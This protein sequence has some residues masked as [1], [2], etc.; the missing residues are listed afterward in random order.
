[1]KKNGK[2]PIISIGEL[3]K[4]LFTRYPEVKNALDIFGISNEKYQLYLAAQRNPVFF[5]SNTTIEGRTI[6]EL[7]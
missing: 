4:D 6:G 7:E 5:T 3:T 2:Q 1:V